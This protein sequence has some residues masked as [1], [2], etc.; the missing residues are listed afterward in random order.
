M[1][2]KGA[3]K[4]ML[5]GHEQHFCQLKIKKKKILT[6]TVSVHLLVISRFKEDTL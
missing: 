2:C 1:S 4:D 3:K 5:S 6:N